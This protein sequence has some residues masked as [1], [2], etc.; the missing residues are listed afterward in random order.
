MLHHGTARRSALRCWNA[1][2]A[3]LQHQPEGSRIE[4]EMVVVDYSPDP[5]LKVAEAARYDV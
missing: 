4:S 1:R 5:G 3:I 2:L